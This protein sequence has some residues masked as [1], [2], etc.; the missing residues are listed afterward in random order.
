MKKLLITASFFFCAC[1]HQPPAIVSFDLPDQAQSIS[2][3]IE[4]LRPENEKEKKGK[5]FTTYLMSP[6]YGIFRVGDET[7]SP[8]IMDVFRWMVFERLGETEKD[9]NV[10]VYH[11]VVYRN[12][13]SRMRGLAVAGILAGPVGA[14]IASNTTASTVNISQS[15]A[16][17]ELFD[18]NSKT[19][20]RRAFYS[21]E[22]NP[23]DA[24]IFVIYIDAAIN[25]K[26]VFVKTMAP[27]VAPEGQQPFV[28]AV[29]G[30][31]QYWLDQYSSQHRP[32]S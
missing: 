7:T 20:T 28:L 21:K 12:L 27:E 2:I 19:E 6:G 31:I 13:K 14:I 32:G 18:R 30:A 15:L 26:R 11:M 4:D 24:P 1:A 3:P 8:P 5:V 25:G 29:K 10:S 17:R 16:D 9:L 22:E 23:E